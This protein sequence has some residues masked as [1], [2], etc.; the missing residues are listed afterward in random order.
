MHWSDSQGIG[1]VRGLVKNT[2]LERQARDGIE[3]TEQHYRRSGQP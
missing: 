3:R 1:Y 2:F